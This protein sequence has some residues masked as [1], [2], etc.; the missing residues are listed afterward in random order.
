V[1]DA[2]GDVRKTCS[3]PRRAARDLAFTPRVSLDQ[4]L[5]RQTEWALARRSAHP[6]A[7]A[8]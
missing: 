7:V 3:D 4:G 5:A 8:A 6:T 2:R 1:R